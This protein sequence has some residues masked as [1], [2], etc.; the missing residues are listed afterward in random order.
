MIFNFPQNPQLEMK[1][2]KSRI[3][4]LTKEECIMEELTTSLHFLIVSRFPRL[5]TEF[6]AL[7]EKLR[8]SNVSDKFEE[9]GHTFTIIRVFE[10]PPKTLKKYYDKDV[11]IRPSR[12]N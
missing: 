4:S 12:N 1:E 7:V 5:N 10:L 8:E 11:I 3:L 6:R 2:I 9:F